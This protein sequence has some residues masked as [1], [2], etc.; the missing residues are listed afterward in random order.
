[1][2]KHHHLLLLLLLLASPAS[3]ALFSPDEAG[4][5]DAPAC[6]LV[7]A[8]RHAEK[9]PGGGGDPSLS[10][11][12]RARAAALSDSLAGAGVG[13][14]LV[15]PTRRARETAAPLAEKTKVEPQAVPLAGGVEAH[16]QG[17][18]KEVRSHAGGT[19]LVVGH[20]NTVPSLLRALGADAG[21]DLADDAYGDLF[22]L[23]LCEGAKAR[24]V[25]A[26]FG[27]SHL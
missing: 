18:A 14:I 10:E 21:P 2:R 7:V 6:T 19:V 26:R 16:V 8:V 23:T 5:G 13:A 1:M 20:S 27:D 24:L 25:R 15:S 22:L 9:D 17:L 11:A 4:A 3:A 12:G